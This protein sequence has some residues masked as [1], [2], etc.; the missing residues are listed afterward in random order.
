M[1]T[2]L[3]WDSS[4]F[5]LK[6]GKVEMEKLT[7][8][9][10]VEIEKQKSANNYDLLYL[11]LD[12]IDNFTINLLVNRGAKLVDQKITYYKKIEAHQKENIVQIEKFKESVTPKL[13]ELAIS[14]G[15]K[16]RFYKDPRLNPHFIKLYSLWIEKSVAKELADEVLVSIHN[17][18]I[19]GFVTLKKNKNEGSIGLIAVGKELRGMGIGKDLLIAAENWFRANNCDDISVITQQEN[20]QACGLYERSGFTINNSQY[21]FHY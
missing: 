18:E 6:I 14:S 7:V 2:Y 15:H 12:Q 16:S 10:L 4:F 8:A 17:E 21:I 20:I 13:F 3:E 19:S 1:I 5:S 9:N 11:F